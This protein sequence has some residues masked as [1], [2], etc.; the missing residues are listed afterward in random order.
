MTKET[1]GLI[2]LGR[3]I[4]KDYNQIHF[5]EDDDARTAKLE[6]WTAKQIGEEL[7]KHYPQRQWTVIVDIPGRLIIIACPSLSQMKGY[8]LHMNDDNI[9]A[10]KRRSVIAAGEVLER[11][12]IS[13]GRHF[14]PKALEELDRIGPRD[15]ALGPDSDGVDPLIRVHK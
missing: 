12:G 13:R 7:V 14:D 2:G 6:M 8:H 9:G 10:L 15:E 11:Y 5:H 3:E 1:T 4:T